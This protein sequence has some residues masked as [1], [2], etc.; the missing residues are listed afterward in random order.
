MYKVDFTPKAI[1][2]VNMLRKKAPT[3]Y[4]KLLRLLDELEQHPT[5]GSGI[6]KPLREDKQGAWSR[7]INQEHRL[8][9]EIHGAEILVLVI[10]AYGHYDD[11]K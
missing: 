1:D 3:A 5:T 7:R 8:V 11:E 4:K 9:Y 6:P 2:D 10:S